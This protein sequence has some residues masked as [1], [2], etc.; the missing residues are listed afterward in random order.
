MKKASDFVIVSWTNSYIKSAKVI[1]EIAE[2]GEED[3][4][5]FS[6]ENEAA[7]WADKHLNW[8]WTVVAL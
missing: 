4:K 5:V 8:N 7:E 6:S 2:D 1:S 3:A